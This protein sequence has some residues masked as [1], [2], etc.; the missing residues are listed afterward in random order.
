M[1]AG[2]EDRASLAHRF[3]PRG[4]PRAPRNAGRISTRGRSSRSSRG[5]PPSPAAPRNARTW[6]RRSRRGLRNPGSEAFVRSWRP[7]IIS[8]F[9]CG[10]LDPGS[11]AGRIRHGTRAAAVR[12][13]D[14]NEPPW[15]SR[16]A[17]GKGAATSRWPRR[18]PAANPDGLRPARQPSWLSAALH[19]SSRLQLS[20]PPRPQATPVAV[21]LWKH[22]PTNHCFHWLRCAF[23]RDL[24]KTF[25]FFGGRLKSREGSRGRNPW[26]GQG[27]TEE[28]PR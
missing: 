14:A 16:F 11:H 25:T 2:N 1:P 22:H 26:L 8:H 23:S 21:H 12:G 18:P 9:A 3:R 20:R 15:R 28:H 13:C 5:R 6:S 27:A 24:R 19:V 17:A 7:R 4:A 10:R